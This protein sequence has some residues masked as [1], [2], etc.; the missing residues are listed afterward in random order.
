MGI[1]RPNSLA[2]LLPL[3]F[4]LRFVC[5]RR[6]R[7]RRITPHVLVWGIGPCMVPVISLHPVVRCG[8]PGDLES[9]LLSPRRGLLPLDAFARRRT[10]TSQEHWRILLFGPGGPQ[11]RDTNVYFDAITLNVVPEPNAHCIV[12]TLAI[13]TTIAPTRRFR[14]H[15]ARN[16]QVPS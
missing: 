8:R 6:A 15:K 14:F 16:H 12:I 10:A 5:L 7:C 3:G 13:A 4:C 9:T 11:E 1:K 2:Q